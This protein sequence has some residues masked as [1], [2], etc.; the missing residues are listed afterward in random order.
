MTSFN[1]EKVKIAPFKYSTA[2]FYK[3]TYRGTISSWNI[4]EEGEKE[5]YILQ[6]IEEIEYQ[7]CVYCKSAI[8]SI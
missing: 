1:N 8:E 3:V 2:S 7:L 5:K 6:Y 4:Q